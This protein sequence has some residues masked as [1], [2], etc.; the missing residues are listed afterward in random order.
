MLE[1]TRGFE[2]SAERMRVRTEVF[3]V[4]ESSNIR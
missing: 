4:E 3:R 2:L 1:A